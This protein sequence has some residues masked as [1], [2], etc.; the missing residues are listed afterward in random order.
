MSAEAR[1]CRWRVKHATAS[2][3]RLGGGATDLLYEQGLVRVRVPV[4]VGQ[5]LDASPGP[6]KALVVQI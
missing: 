6:A 4:A 1:Y 2:A 5:L 3:S